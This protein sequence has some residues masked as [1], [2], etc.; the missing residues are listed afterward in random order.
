MKSSKIICKD[1]TNDESSVSI[2]HLE[3]LRNNS[4]LIPKRFISNYESPAEL[5]KIDELLSEEIVSND[6]NVES[7]PF[8][9]CEFDEIKVNCLLDTGSSCNLINNDVVVKYKGYFRNKIVRINKMSVRCSNGRLIAILDRMVVT[10]IKM[11]SE[12]LF[13]INLFIINSLKYDMIIGYE[14]LKANKANVNLYKGVIEL[15]DMKVIIKGYSNER[16]IENEY[17]VIN[18]I[19]NN[20]NN[21]VFNEEYDIKC[22]TEQFKIEIESFLS[23]NLNL[24]DETTCFAKSFEYN[25][26]INHE[27]K[28]NPQNYGVPY[29]YKERLKVEIDKMLENGII[30]ITTSPYISPLV[31]VEKKPLNP[32]SL[33]ELRPCLDCRAIN[34]MVSKE[35]CLP[36]SIESLLAKTSNCNI[37]TSLDLKSSFNLLPLNPFCRKYFSFIL[38]GIVYSYT[39]MPF[40]YINASSALV[41]ALRQVLGHLQFVSMYIDDILIFSSTPERHI[42]DVLQVLQL[43]SEYGFKLNASKC[44]FFQKTV[45]FLGFMISANK[46]TLDTSR[47][48]AIQNYPRPCNVKQVRSYLGV[49][50]YYNKFIPKYA[51]TLIPLYDLLKKGVRFKWTEREQEAFDNIKESF[52]KNIHLMIADFNY[53]FILAC[54][55]S[56]SAIGSI[57]FQEIDGCRRIVSYISKRLNPAQRNYSINELELLAIVYSVNKLKYYLSG[58]TFTILTDNISLLSILKTRSNNYSGKIIRWTLFLQTFSFKILHITSKQNIIADSLSR[59]YSKENYRKNT[60]YINYHNLKG[61]TDPH[62]NRNRIIHEQSNDPEL[63]EIFDK[64]R[65]CNEYKGY[66]IKDGLLVKKIRS[67]KI[68]IYLPKRYYNTVVLYLH[69]YYIHIG[70]RQLFLVIRENFITKNDYPL[71]KKITSTCEDC[72]LL[73]HKNFTPVV[74]YLPIKR[75]IPFH[76]VS[77]DFLSGFIESNGYRN[78]FVVIDNYS[79]FVKLYNTKRTNTITVI[80]CLKKYIKDIPFKISNILLDRATYNLTSTLDNFLDKQGIKKII[81]PVRAPQANLS[82]RI[83]LSILSYLRF[84]VRENHSSWP[85]YTSSIENNINQLPSTVSGIAPIIFL[86]KTFPKRPWSN[87]SVPINTTQLLAKTNEIYNK[88]QTNKMNKFIKNN[89]KKKHIFT[90]KKNDLVLIKR[91]NTTDFTK[92]KQCRKFMPIFNL[93]RVE[94]KLG[95]NTYEVKILN[96]GRRQV[97]TSRNMYPYL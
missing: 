12:F 22:G 54:D 88:L 80:N 3:N 10:S 2:V 20:C 38:D 16:V 40:G 76:T 62:F 34:R 74:Q 36:E 57:L 55:S 96:T 89:K 50:N 1:V 61:V 44:S 39:C 70:S 14:F 43:L 73:K 59:C 93:A 92:F 8:I 63:V 18:N 9:E 52:H 95:I 90:Y 64:L 33:P 94:S 5:F 48:E 97:H 46:V 51:G 53:P 85:E 65:T 79:K 35:V 66:E 25:F 21:K 81:L 45:K 91:I 67:G 11:N 31:I 27:I 17:N 71:I 82:E 49:I 68:L 37:Y 75:F 41:K 23:D 30:E 4:N 47:I 42:K 26:D 60:L 87:S 13:P 72:Q 7:L 78:I 29:K 6:E 69:E 15:N 24:I 84:L 83:N 58:N 32:D 19:N 28:F 77:V 56:N 86:N